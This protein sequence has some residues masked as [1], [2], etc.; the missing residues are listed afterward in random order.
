MCGKENPADLSVCQFCQA[1]LKPLTGPLSDEPA[2]TG[3]GDD[4]LGS[5]RSESDLAGDEE[6]E[7]LDEEASDRLGE[8]FRDPLERLSALNGTSPKEHTMREPEPEY[9]PEDE[10]AGEPLGEEIGGEKVDLGAWLASLD[11]AE[12]KAEQVPPAVKGELPDWL[13]EHKDRTALPEPG[14]EDDT[15]EWL[16]GLTAGTGGFAAAGEAA[17]AETESFLYA[18]ETSDA[19][20]EMPDWLKIV[21]EG[22][23]A[24][25]LDEVSSPEEQDLPAEQDAF[26]DWLAESGFEEAHPEPT[27]ES[28]VGEEVTSDLD[29]I[30]MPDFPAWQASKDPDEDLPGVTEP[31][32]AG[33]L[34]QWLMEAAGEEI[35]TGPQLAGEDTEEFPEWLSILEETDM[36]AATGETPL[37]PGDL[38]DWLRESQP[39]EFGIE[40]P[41]QV[42]ELDIQGLGFER[43]S[44]Q[45]VGG[46]PD[47]TGDEVAEAGELESIEIPDWLADL[48][49][50]KEQIGELAEIPDL[51][52]MAIAPGPENA[53]DWLSALAS[54]AGSEQGGVKSEEA[55]S[56]AL[57]AAAAAALAPFAMDSDLG[58][59]DKD[60]Y[61]GQE[62]EWLAD[63]TRDNTTDKV[64]GIEEE[65]IVRADLPEWL[66]AMRPMDAVMASKTPAEEPTGEVESAG[67]LAGLADV[68][69]AEADLFQISKPESVSVRLDVNEAQQRHIVLLEQMLKQEVRESPV[70]PTDRA[71]SDRLIRWIVFAI[72]FTAA[73][74]SIFRGASQAALPIPG[75]ETQA[76]YTAIN[77]LQAQAPVLVAFDYEPGLAG[78]L[79]IISTSLMDHLMLRGA[80]LTIVSTTPTGPIQAEN[81]I[82]S[83]NTRYNYV[84]DSQYVN[85]G[86]IPG[87]PTGLQTL[88]NFPMRFVLPYTFSG[89]EAWDPRLMP[90]ANVEALSDYALIL[91]LTDRQETGRAWIEQIG[92]QTGSAAFLLGISAQIEPL[93][94]PYYGGD[95]NFVDG[96]VA[97]LSGG[98]AY[99]SL[100]G[101]AGQGSQ[102][103]RT[104]QLLVLVAA[105]L[106]LAGGL[107]SLLFSLPGKKQSSAKGE[108][109]NEPA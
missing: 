69:P 48:E 89:Y 25:P 2:Q 32:E 107:V 103:W 51:E 10:D 64:E 101:Q 104:Y 28:Q 99:E 84:R 27:V 79:E 6:N 14:A 86:Y 21:G 87:G 102:Y 46:L 60:F 88:V 36:P 58:D 96:F 54:D 42:D 35:E 18:E 43:I 63:V 90:L 15:P 11:E 68:L 30:Q 47:L 78:E 50:A 1:R 53:D 80:A 108:Q 56:S 38:P 8:E 94:R 22:P 82:Q 76:V 106:I 75:P 77:A 3:A 45:P 65:G 44:E 33:D 23:S 72:L 81:V 100:V 37:E 4:W 109:S 16:A 52:M 13:Q 73:I 98:G 7:W 67:P 59:E 49:P 105:V 24:L 62:P 95:A 57:A 91:V 74:I 55:D 61:L 97:G 93:V 26:P 20:A 29:R 31:A 12:P 66:A 39:P 83:L 71:V 34:P 92:P 85:L 5:L 17:P 70:S 41:E 19:D 9:Q 40:S